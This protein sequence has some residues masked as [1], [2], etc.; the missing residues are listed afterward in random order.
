MSNQIFINLLNRA[1]AAEY[2]G[3]KPRTLDV[4]AS[5]RRYNLKFIKVGRLAKYRKEDLDEFLTRRTI[6]N[7]GGL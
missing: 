5:T 3:V 6:T 4:W 7:D 1:E 2:L